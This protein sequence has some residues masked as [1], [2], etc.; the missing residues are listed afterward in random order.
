MT[1]IA[2]LGPAGT[3]CE[4]ALLTQA[5]LAQQ[6]LVAYMTIEDALQALSNHTVDMAFLPMENAIEGTVNVTMDALAFDHHMLI[7]REVVLPIVMTL[8]ARPGV[9][10]ADVTT[11]MS[12]PM[13][14]AQCR[15]YFA[16]YLPG[17]QVMAA[18]STAEAARLVGESDSTTIAT[19]GPALSGKLYGLEVLATDIA[20]HPG[21]ET[22]FV[23]LALSGVP[24]PT[25]HDKTSIVCFQSFDRP[26]SLLAMLQEFAARAINL[27][28]LESR[29]T[30]NG[31]GNYCFIID[32]EGHIADELVADCLRNL[33]AKTAEVK[34]LGSFPAA[35]D[36]GP[37]K[38][39][40]ATES[41]D[42]ASVWLESYRDQIS[43]DQI[44]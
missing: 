12:M 13:A 32:L 27:V 37:A 36:H 35:G 44:S 24:A 9:S 6:D 30:K 15:Q 23:L 28:K 40:E 7:Q 16:K 10:A 4:E 18:G 1:R 19:V 38:R 31:L 42:R 14:T 17:V 2:Y 22:R 25:G 3:F 41:W 5:D 26:G 21:N 20:D 29:P 39:V 34:M 8:M 43:R 11:V 33:A